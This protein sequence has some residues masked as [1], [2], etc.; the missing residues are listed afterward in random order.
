[1]G[2]YEGRY[3]IAPTYSNNGNLVKKFGTDDF[4]LLVQSTS[5]GAISYTSSN[6]AVATINGN[7]VTI[8][9]AGQTEITLNQTVTA[10]YLA[11]TTTFILI[12]NKAEQ[13]ITHPTV[14]YKQ[15]GSEDFE[16]D[17]S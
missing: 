2:A 9:G 14:V 8:T 15:L 10:N 11:G 6:E 1:L 7:T 12:V 17:A 4:D 3:T 5:D 16:L 13:V